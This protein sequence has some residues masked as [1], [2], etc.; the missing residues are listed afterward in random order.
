MKVLR[1][2]RMER[3][4]YFR[5]LSCGGK[6][7]RSHGSSLD[8]PSGLG[9]V[10]GC[11]CDAGWRRG[12]GRGRDRRSSGV[13]VDGRLNPGSALVRL[14]RSCRLLRSSRVVG[15]VFGGGGR[16]LGIARNQYQR[17]SAARQHGDNGCQVDSSVF[18]GGSRAPCCD[19]CLIYHPI[20]EGCRYCG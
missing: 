20:G 4:R 15:C 1:H 18:C 16:G 8:I 12:R 9:W 2:S 6:D 3:E 10:R 19:S 13:W 5:T 11:G 17:T 7:R 14:R